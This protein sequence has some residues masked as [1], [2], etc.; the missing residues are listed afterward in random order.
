MINAGVTFWS[1]LYFSI[2]MHENSNM[3]MYEFNYTPGS[4]IEE[5]GGSKPSEGEILATGLEWVDMS[6]NQKY[7]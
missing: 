6:C 7:R 4:R 1:T 2:K 5:E 3:C